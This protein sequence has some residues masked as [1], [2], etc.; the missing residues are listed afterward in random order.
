MMLAP[1]W[2]GANVAKEWQPISALTCT[3]PSSF[4]TIFIDEKN[5]RSGQP[6]HKLGGRSGTVLRNDSIGTRGRSTGGTAGAGGA[7]GA[8]ACGAQRARNALSPW[9]MTM[10][11]YS[12]AMGNGPLPTTA[13][14]MSALRRN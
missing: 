6:V 9:L 1:I 4:W 5:G 14:W 13:V 7:T 11:V 2:N 8:K 10:P 3:L 12:P